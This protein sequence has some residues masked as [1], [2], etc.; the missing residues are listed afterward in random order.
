MLRKYFLLVFFALFAVGIASA[1]TIV[2]YKGRYGQ[3]DPIAH[4]DGNVI[5]KGRYG[6]A[7]PIAHIDGA[8]NLIQ[9]FAILILL[10]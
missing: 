1:E 2:I 5:Y 3:A 9:L 10:L 4:I 8:V 7:D 6:Q